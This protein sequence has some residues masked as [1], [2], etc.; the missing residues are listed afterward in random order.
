MSDLAN[1]LSD[2]YPIERINKR[3]VRVIT[4]QAEMDIVPVIEYGD[5]YKIADREISDWKATNPPGHNAWSSKQNTYFNQRF[6]PM[7]KLFKWWRS[8]NK[9]GKRPKGFVLEMLVAIHAPKDEYHYGEAFATMLEN[10]YDEY[11]DL[12]EN[13]IKP[14]L[15][16]PSLPENN[17]LSKVSITD[18]K[19]FIN[20]V[21]VHAGYARKAQNQDDD[22]MDEAT[23]LWRK[24]F[25][26]RF[27]ATTNKVNSNNLSDYST[28]PTTSVAYSFPNA[29]AAPKKPRGFA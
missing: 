25:G 16:D 10:I 29:P 2:K 5:I 7:V 12:S 23:R 28:A 9:S 20:R 24:L 18:W 13:D 27:K 3:S 11:H 4:S 6:K 21:G 26:A 22:K 19:N 17:I 15:S 1:A 14:F 8:E